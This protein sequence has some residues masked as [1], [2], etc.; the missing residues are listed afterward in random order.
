MFGVV[1]SPDVVRSTVV[2]FLR[3][4]AIK[5]KGRTLKNN[6]VALVTENSTVAPVG[7]DGDG[8]RL[9]YTTKATAAAVTTVTA[10]TIISR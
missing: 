4:R 8:V 6:T 9:D 2:L 1:V 7:G 3:R 5:D 10:I